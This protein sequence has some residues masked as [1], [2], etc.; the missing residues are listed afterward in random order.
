MVNFTGSTLTQELATLARLAF[1]LFSSISGAAVALTLVA[2]AFNPGLALAAETGIRG[3]DVTLIEGEDRT[4]YE[5]RQN[6][7]LRIVRIV[8]RFGKAYYLVPM[9]PTQCYG[10]LEC[11]DMLIPRWKIIEF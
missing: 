5:Y 11:A 6:G 7:Q 3:P 8:P 1:P 2:A 4:I 10:D 9:D